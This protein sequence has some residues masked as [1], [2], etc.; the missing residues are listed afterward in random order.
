M[1]IKLLKDYSYWHDGELFTAKAGMVTTFQVIWDLMSG[2]PYDINE[3]LKYPDLFKIEYEIDD[4]VFN[5]R[6]DKTMPKVFK[7]K[8]IENVEW[9][10]FLYIDDSRSDNYRSTNCDASYVRPATKLE[11]KEYKKINEL[12][13]PFQYTIGPGLPRE[14]FVTVKKTNNPDELFLIKE[15]SDFGVPITKKGFIEIN[16]RTGWRK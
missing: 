13:F 11:I 16:K 6:R 4:I 7:I 15:D 12:E 2:M 9:G 3:V 14:L 1:K 10:V 5:D 8:H